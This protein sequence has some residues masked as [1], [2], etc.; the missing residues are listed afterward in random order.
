MWSSDENPRDIVSWLLKAMYEKDGTGPPSIQAL[1]QDT[2]LLLIAGRCV[3][4]YPDAKLVK[5]PVPEANN[6]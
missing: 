1:D 5:Q 6:I 4:Y 2:K 3:V